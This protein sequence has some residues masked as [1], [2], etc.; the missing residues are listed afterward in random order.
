HDGAGI[1]GNVAS[2]LR[3]DAAGT[4][5]CDG[6]DGL[7]F[8]LRG[9]PML[10]AFANHGGPD[11]SYLPL[12]GS[13]LLDAGSAGLNDSATDQRGA[14]FARIVGAAIDI[15]AIEAGNADDDDT[16]F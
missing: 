7:D 3:T 11:P 14:G 13:P 1:V 10:S 6:F 2:L 5:A 9:D 12:P 8:A 4:S 16:I 15:G